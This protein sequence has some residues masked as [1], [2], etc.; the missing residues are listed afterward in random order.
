MPRRRVLADLTPLR[1]SRDYRLLFSGQVA[2]YIG[3]QFTVVAIPIQ[4]FKITHSSL[5]VGLV[6]MAQLV[7]LVAG[8]LIGG[9]IADSRDRRRLL[10]V[11]LVLLALA[12]VPLALNARAAHPALWPIIAFSALAAGLSGIERPARSAV[13]PAL[14]PKDELTAAY[15]LWQILIQVGSVVGPA[16]AGLLLAGVGLPAVYLIDVLTF[17]VAVAA[18]SH[19]PPL[20]PAGGGTK[21][22]GRLDR[23]G[24]ALPEGPD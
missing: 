18:I 14:V 17:L 16:V 8:S 2:S 23:G 4:V 12:G 1:E 9:A 7:P 3:R 24:P 21:G 13:I 22:R 20:P 6:S 10:M 15:A 5:D 19:L 11:T